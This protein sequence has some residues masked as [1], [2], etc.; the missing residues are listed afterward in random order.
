MLSIGS[1]EVVYVG[2]DYPGRVVIVE[3]EN[4]LFSMYGHLDAGTIV[5]EGT[6]VRPGDMLGSVF[7]RTDGQAPSHLHI[8]LRTFL[9]NDRIN[10]EQPEHGTPCGFNC[11]PGPGYWPIAA[12]HPAEM[13][14]RNPTVAIAAEAFTGRCF[15][16][17]HEPANF[18]LMDE[19]LG[20]PVVGVVFEPGDAVD[21]EEVWAGESDSLETSSESYQIWGR[22]TLAGQPGWIR[23]VE[24][25]N[26]ARPT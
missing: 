23:L 25:D 5:A 12:E 17:G 9:L 3:Q 18:G 6:V 16:P 11:P 20:E 22:V 10:G 8:E 19:P 7:R 21:V 14:W 24:P 1:G 15:V 2:S 4:G 13:G 26:S